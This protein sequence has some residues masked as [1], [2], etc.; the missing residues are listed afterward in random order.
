LDL[1]AGMLL[2]GISKVMG[3]SSGFQVLVSILSLHTRPTFQ[4]L[5]TGLLNVMT[6]A[7]LF[8]MVDDIIFPTKR[9]SAGPSFLPKF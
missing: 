2:V 1:F 8:T 7:D 9:C 5:S 4:I 6:E 3:I